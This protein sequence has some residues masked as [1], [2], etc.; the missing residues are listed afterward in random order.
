[1]PLYLTVSTYFVKSYRKIG[2]YNIDD[3]NLLIIL[4]MLHNTCIMYMYIMYV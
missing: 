3:K 4:Y 2:I 1:M